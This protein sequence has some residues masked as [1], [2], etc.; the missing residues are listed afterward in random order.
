MK[1]LLKFGGKIGWAICFILSIFTLSSYGQQQAVTGKITS[2]DDGQGITGVSVSV[3]GS[4]GQ[5]RLIKV[6][7]TLSK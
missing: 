5:P 2:S 3:K 7:Y 6:A 4:V 1:S